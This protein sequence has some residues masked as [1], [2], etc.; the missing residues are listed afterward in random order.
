MGQRLIGS[1]HGRQQLCQFLQR[2]GALG[3]QSAGRRHAARLG[4]KLS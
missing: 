3:P 2:G 4:M 1:V